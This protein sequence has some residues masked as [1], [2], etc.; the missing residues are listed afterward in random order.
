MY[1][2]EKRKEFTCDGCVCIIGNY[3]EDSVGSRRHMLSNHIIDA[4]ERQSEKFT[5]TMGSLLCITGV[6]FGMSGYLCVFGFLY[7]SVSGAVRFGIMIAYW[8]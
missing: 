6:I 8:N 3:S 1:L 4:S 7:N 5:N 2:S